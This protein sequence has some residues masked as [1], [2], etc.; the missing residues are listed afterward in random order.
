VG[1]AACCIFLIP[2]G[3]ETAYFLNAEDKAI[4]RQRAE[5]ME[6]Y[7]GSSGKHGKEDIKKAIKDPKSWLHGL[8]QICVVTI[9]YGMSPD[10]VT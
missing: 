8:I 3:Y 10:A 5:I 1:Y 7:S 9:L 6:S 4:M 2:K